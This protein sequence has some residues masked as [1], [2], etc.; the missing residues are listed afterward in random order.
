MLLRKLGLDNVRHSLAQALRARRRTTVRLR[1]ENLEDRTVP[2]FLAPVNS[3]GV[4]S[5][6]GDFNGDG[7]ADLAV[8]DYDAH[9]L[10][11]R[12]GNGDGT[13]QPAGPAQ[14]VQYPTGATVAD[15]DGDGK[16]D[17]LTRSYG[18]NVLRGNG[19]GTLQPPIVS[20]AIGSVT[21]WQ[22][23]DMNNDGRPD[24]VAR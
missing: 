15:F 11:V 18:L 6:V 7:R 13:F 16:L 12:L 20:G 3:P 8:T 5:A 10:S 4:F 17:V 19:D 21:S 23:A 1:C 9:S 24:A 14:P 22:I 2:S